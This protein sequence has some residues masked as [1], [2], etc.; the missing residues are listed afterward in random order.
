M[1]SRKHALNCRSRLTVAFLA[2]MLPSIATGDEPLRWKFR[3]DERI[4]IE[5]DQNSAVRETSQ[6]ESKIRQRTSL[7]WRVI[8]VDSEGTATIEQRTQRLRLSISDSKEEHSA[9][10]DTAVAPGALH[11]KIKTIWAIASA[12]MNTTLQFRLSS[13]GDIIDFETS[14]PNETLHNPKVAI[15]F[16]KSGPKVGEP[17]TVQSHIKKKD[18]KL[19]LT[20]SY[21]LVG[22]ETIDGREL[23]KIKTSTAFQLDEG[24][25]AKLVSQ[26]A[27]GLFWFD[28]AE[29]KLARSENHQEIGLELQRD[30]TPTVQSIQQSTEISYQFES[31]RR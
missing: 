14:Q 1:R 8:E 10:S 26:N 18:W 6:A 7:A 20:T 30:A 3:K 12:P 28:P 16:P 22:K 15:V 5:V 9:D 27:L 21:Q 11:P 23:S 19:L 24:S 17:W 13:F 4:A 31:V 25:E 2:G 29:G